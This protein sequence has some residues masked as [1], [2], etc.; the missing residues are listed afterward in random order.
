MPFIIILLVSS[1]FTISEG[2]QVECGQAPVWA[3]VG[4]IL[5]SGETEEEMMARDPHLCYLKGQ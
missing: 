1:V 3:M 5:V 4:G 2:S